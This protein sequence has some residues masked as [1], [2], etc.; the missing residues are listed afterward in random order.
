[1]LR[2]GPHALP[3]EQIFYETVHALA[4]TNLRPVLP[5]HVLVLSRRAVARFGD[6]SAAEAADVWCAAQA[7]GRV[8][9]ACHGGTSATYSL[10]DGAEAGQSVPHLHI[11]IV[12][13][14]AAD[15]PCNDDVYDLLEASRSE[16][17]V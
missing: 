6:L 14:R 1:M 12:P 10:Q 5:G 15:L 16:G 2:F 8:V 4:I 11:H 3:R 13:R 7:V 9:T 17:V